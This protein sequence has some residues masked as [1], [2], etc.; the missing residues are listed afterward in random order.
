MRFRMNKFNLSILIFV[1]CNVTNVNAKVTD[2]SVGSIGTHFLVEAYYTN[3]E[4]AKNACF[5]FAERLNYSPESY[6]HLYSSYNDEPAVWA[7]NLRE[8]KDHPWY[9]GVFYY[10][11]TCE[12]SGYFDYLEGCTVPEDKNAG[13]CKV[14]DGRPMAGNPVNIGIGRKFQKEIDIASSRSNRLGFIRYYNSGNTNQWTNTFSR[15]VRYSEETPNILVV[16]RPDGYGYKAP[17]ENGQWVFESDVNGDVVNITDTNG[18]L[19]GW[20]FTTTEDALEEYD[21]NGNLV[22]ITE[23]DGYQQTLN[24]SLTTVQGGDDNPST[25]DSVT[26]SFGRTLF[27]SYDNEKRLASL[28]DPN[29]AIYFYTYDGNSNLTSVAYPDTTPANATDNPTR[30]YH[31]EDANFPHALT[32]ITD[33]K[34]Q[35]FATWT[36]DAQGRVIVSEHAD[37]AERVELTYDETTQ[38]T[39]VKS[40]IHPADGS[41]AELAHEKTYTFSLINGIKK[42]TQIDGGACSSCSGQMQSV[43][44]DGNGYRD[45]NTDLNGYITDFDHDAN[46][47]QTQRTEAVGTNEQRRIVTQWHTDY[48][49]PTQIDVYDKNDTLIKRT[50]NTYDTQGRLAGTTTESF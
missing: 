13:Q 35:R 1:L 27:F 36:Y 17:L 30:I 16:T 43:T 7:G 32:G 9:L 33:E 18:N 10:E 48:R 26:D 4:A 29:G 15:T 49:L 41:E 37:S 23:R 5:A 21:I 2:V 50:I 28:S 3:H 39:T 45:L 8:S 40:I 34:G 42:V 22:S 38:S 14:G 11:I 25:L 31:Y 47:L 19:T 46:G 20:Q 44:Y 12:I 6:C 24:Y